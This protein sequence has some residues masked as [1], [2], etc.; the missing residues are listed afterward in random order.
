MYYLL[1]VIHYSVAS[2]TGYLNEALP[3]IK[4]NAVKGVVLYTIKGFCPLRRFI[5]LKAKILCY[6]VRP[7]PFSIL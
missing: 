1:E 6:I 5:Y 7:F 4:Q 3:D 2:I